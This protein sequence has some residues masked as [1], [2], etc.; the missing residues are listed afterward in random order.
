[1]T[2]TMELLVKD[3]DSYYNLLLYVP[4]GKERAC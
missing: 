2:K 4:E 1:M 3:I